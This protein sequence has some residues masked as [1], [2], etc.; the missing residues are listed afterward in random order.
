M[1]NTLFFQDQAGKYRT[2]SAVTKQQI[3]NFARELIIPDFIGNTI[4]SSSAEAASF[5]QIAL[6]DERK[7]NFGVIFLA[8]SMKVIAFEVLETGTISVNT[9]YPRNILTRVIELNAQYVVLAHNHPSGTIQPSTPDYELTKK[10]QKVLEVIDVKV[11]D[12]IIV[13]GNKYFSF[14]D[15]GA[16][17]QTGGK[18]HEQS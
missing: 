15:N 17:N 3:I 9:I 7:E 2:K 8:S 5:L 13:G 4:L 10:I 16:L 6:A 1:S 14:A 11:Q 12:H 18:F